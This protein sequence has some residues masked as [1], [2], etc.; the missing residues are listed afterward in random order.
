[1]Q[2]IKQFVCLTLLLCSSLTAPS[3]SSG[4]KP[5]STVTPAPQPAP[6]TDALTVQ[7]A[8]AELAD[9]FAGVNSAGKQHHV[10]E[11]V[12][13]ALTSGSPGPGVLRDRCT[14]IAD[15]VG[16]REVAPI[17]YA[18]CAGAALD[19]L[20]TFQPGLRLEVLQSAIAL[21][22]PDPLR[23]EF[24]RALQGR[25]TGELGFPEVA[26]ADNLTLSNVLGR[27]FR[28]SAVNDA[29]V[30]RVLDTA[31]DD[32]L[33]KLLDLFVPALDEMVRSTEDGVSARNPATV[34]AAMC[35]LR[36][37]IALGDHTIEGGS[38]RALGLFG[39]IW[40]GIKS[41]GSAAL[42][43]A[44]TLMTG[45]GLTGVI[46]AARNVVGTISSVVGGVKSL[47]GGGSNP[48]F[49][50]NWPNG[51]A[52]TQRMLGSME[53]LMRQTSNEILA[54]LNDQNA[55]LIA[56]AQKLSE[57][58]GR[59]EQRF[60]ELTQLI[61]DLNRNLT[62]RLREL[63]Q[64]LDALEENVRQFVA[65]NLSDLAAEIEERFTQVLFQAMND[66]LVHIQSKIAGLRA[67][68]D[69]NSVKR[70]VAELS[71]LI[72]GSAQSVLV[73][74]YAPSE[75]EHN[76]GQHCKS[77]LPFWSVVSLEVLASGIGIGNTILTTLGARPASIANPVALSLPSIDLAQ[78]LATS[79]FFPTQA[80]RA[81][82]VRDL[83][84]A[85]ENGRAAL[86][87]MFGT[88]LQ[89]TT[90][91][92]DDLLAPAVREWGE[93]VRVPY[94]PKINT[95][96]RTLLDRWLIDG[97]I[98]AS[99]GYARFALDREPASFASGRGALTYFVNGEGPYV[100]RGYDPLKKLVQL[101]LL[102]VDGAGS[103]GFALVWDVGDLPSL[104]S[105]TGTH[106]TVQLA[107]AGA[108]L[109]VRLTVSGSTAIELLAA[110]ERTLGLFEQDFADIVAHRIEGADLR[111]VRSLFSMQSATRLLLELARDTF[112]ADAETRV[113]IVALLERPLVFSETLATLLGVDPRA[114]L[115]W[116]LYVK[117][118]LS[119]QIARL[120]RR[121]VELQYLDGFL[122]A[123]RPAITDLRADATT[124]ARAIESS[125]T[126]L[127][128]GIGV[129]RAWIAAGS[130][131]QGAS[132]A[133]G[134]RK[135]VAR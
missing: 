134:D 79:E 119:A 47:V 96:D 103:A 70:T 36:A 114:S 45:G 9:A 29:D 16:R 33:G 27:V 110:A 40:S 48:R 17:L 25:L 5:P 82:A 111:S 39:S 105:Y 81:A 94:R 101:G 69:P 72:I 135:Q 77:L 92:L 85:M 71:A 112:V 97:T 11:L 63:S 20:A 2:P 122:G 80:E 65:D 12:R 58:Y 116:S 84:A 46:S 68:R 131:T 8:A 106:G 132:G 44:T 31:E 34:A 43:T 6:I 104:R 3:C 18:V 73:F 78:A 113:H 32:R 130:A 21:A 59:M 60:A 53:R 56:I 75:V 74:A 24:R 37:L 57:L 127:D 49:T 87:G 38:A 121:E 128:Y 7:V 129:L 123:L 35:R 89:L 109:E 13:L 61:G 23:G 99:T 50:I 64:R 76:L 15:R 55:K 93:I 88:G 41:V 26:L 117:G 120:F 107:A 66:A 67:D 52:Q 108:E 1:M 62:E 90:A 100:P 95:S 28:G 30:L 126:V 102:R 14:A 124:L 98:D 125:P 4:S 83:L 51:E 133:N 118:L 91:R 115:S 19:G 10:T 86:V 54:R 42:S 22:L